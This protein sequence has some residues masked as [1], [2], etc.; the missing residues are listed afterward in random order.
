[1]FYKTLLN[2]FILVILLIITV[3]AQKEFNQG[4]SLNAEILQNNAILKTEDKIFSISKE[5]LLEWEFTGGKIKQAISI[6]DINYDS[7]KEIVAATEGSVPSVK[8]IDGKSG[9]TLQTHILS[10]KTYKNNYPI[11]TSKIVNTNGQTYLSNFNKIYRIDKLELTQI[12]EFQDYIEDFNLI[13]GNF[14][15]STNRKLISYTMNFDKINEIDKKGKFFIEQNYAVSS[16]SIGSPETTLQLYDSNLNKIAK[17]SVSG[18]LLGF[19]NDNIILMDE[20][21]TGTIRIYSIYGKEL[22]KIENVNNIEIKSNDYYIVQNNQ[23]KKGENIVYD[24]TNITNSNEKITWLGNS[25]IGTYTNEII[26]IYKDKKLTVTISKKPNQIIKNLGNSDFVIEKTWPYLYNY[27]GNTGKIATNQKIQGKSIHD[28]EDLSDVNNDNFNELLISFS[29]GNYWLEEIHSLVYL[30]PKTGKTTE[31]S[32]VPTPEEI[33]QTIQQIKTKIDDLNSRLKSKNDKINDLNNEI[34]ELSI[35]LQQQQTPEERTT[36][37][38]KINKLDNEIKKLYD[39]TEILNQEKFKFEDDKRFWESPNVELQMNIASYVYSGSGKV[40]TALR[41]GRLYLIDIKTGEKQKIAIKEDQNELSVYYLDKAGDVN[42]DGIEDIIFTLGNG[43]GV[44]SGKDYNVIWKKI[45]DNA[46]LIPQ[47]HY[48]LGNSIVISS[49][50]KIIRLD[51]LNGAQLEERTFKSPQFIKHVD[52]LVIYGLQKGI[53]IVT[54]TQI[55]ELSFINY[56]SYQ[57]DPKNTFNVLDCNMDNK[58]DL[59]IVSSNWEES[60]QINC[61][62][63]SS[64]TLINNIMPERNTK[65]SSYSKDNEILNLKEFRTIDNKFIILNLDQSN[66][67]GSSSYSVEN[68]NPNGKIIIDIPSKKIIGMSLL[69]YYFINEK[70]YNL[71]GT[72]IIQSD[73]IINPRDNQYF[74]GDFYIN[75]KDNNIRLIYVDNLFYTLTHES[76]EKIQ[77]IDGQHEIKVLTLHP[78]NE[79]IAIDSIITN[80]NREKSTIK[81]YFIFLIMLSVLISGALIKWKKTNMQ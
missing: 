69:D 78:N 48:K 76:K 32:F 51:L 66:S 49:G 59:A 70:L 44:V 54:P 64:G 17:F 68:F 12:I 25:I 53:V 42:R 40:L 67:Y 52:E 6:E 43:V 9:K 14:V 13:N 21:Q 26:K 38:N 62:D 45:Y 57:Q 15:I 63:I 1:M 36:T 5:G 81:S 23:I 8:I 3:N 50:D 18:T 2:I 55:K 41:S 77:L 35:K 29:S 61:I 19:S 75:F 4:P 34:N 47:S 60:Y 27:N 24:A 39:E 65:D 11:P 72:E 73:N 20:M 22:R 74:D 7:Y 30:E 79:F 28:I 58:K 71:D 56:Y 80:V 16:Y 10:K 46:G 37:Q 31:I 33:I